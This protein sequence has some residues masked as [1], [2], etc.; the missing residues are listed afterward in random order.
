MSLRLEK[1]WGVWT[2]DFRPD[3]TA[4]ES[5]LDM[6]IDW[7]KDFIGKAA[8]LKEREEGPAKKLVTLIV[9]TNDID[10]SNDE[11]ILLNGE[12]IG[13]V[14]S[15]GYAHQTAKSIAMGYVPTIHACG[16]KLLQVEI[17][18]AL[19]DAEVQSQP[20]YDA[21]GQRMRA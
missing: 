20:L 5:G 6:F 3:F 19:Y 12:A 9:E 4:A 8:A 7:K 10:V 16:G 13:Y 15:G 1:A 11:A 17:N 2:L 14:S 18:G 21:G